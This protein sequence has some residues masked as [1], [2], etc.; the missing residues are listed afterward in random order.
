MPPVS[1]QNAI[2]TLALNETSSSTDETNYG[3]MR[4]GTGGQNFPVILEVGDPL[5]VYQ[6]AKS[7][8]V[9]VHSYLR[10]IYF[11]EP[12]YKQFFR[13]LTSAVRMHYYISKFLFINF[14]GVLSFLFFRN[15][16]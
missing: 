11:D 9:R 2:C 12:K 4:G 10:D 14:C 6:S 13:M 8:S 16:L 3:G 5:I 1:R 7:G 15:K